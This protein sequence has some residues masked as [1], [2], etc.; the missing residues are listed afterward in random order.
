MQLGG[1]ADTIMSI[2]NRNAPFYVAVVVGSSRLCDVTEHDDRTYE[3]KSISQKRTGLVL[4]CVE[5][6]EQQYRFAA[7]VATMA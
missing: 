3:R 7:D 4:V 5:E 1:I 6:E 2:V